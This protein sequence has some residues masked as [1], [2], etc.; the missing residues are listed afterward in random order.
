MVSVIYDEDESSTTS[1][2]TEHS[3]KQVL[4]KRENEVEGRRYKYNERE[5]YDE[6]LNQS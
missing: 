2:V 6:E 5:N 4:R 3:L 1:G